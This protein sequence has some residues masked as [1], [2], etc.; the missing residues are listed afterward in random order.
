ME[1]GL[2]LCFLISCVIPVKLC[3]SDMVLRRGTITMSHGHNWQTLSNKQHNWE[4]CKGSH[5]VQHKGT[6]HNTTNCF[7]LIN[8]HANMSVRKSSCECSSSEALIQR[9][10]QPRNH[11]PL[12]VAASQAECSPAKVFKRK[13]LR[14]KIMRRGATM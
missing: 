5:H 6:D 8:I 3:Y 14:A 1:N 13:G 10:L 2:T 9:E 4:E 7:N 11:N 12:K